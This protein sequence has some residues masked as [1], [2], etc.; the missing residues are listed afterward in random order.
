MQMSRDTLAIDSVLGFYSMILSQARFRLSMKRR[1]ESEERHGVQMNG[2]N[3]HSN[4]DHSHAPTPSGP[5]ARASRSK[6]VK[7][8]KNC[9][10]TP[11]HSG[12]RSP[13]SSAPT[14]TSSCRYDSSLG[15]LTKKFIELIKQADD[16]VLDLN[17]AADTLN[18][19]KRRIYDITNVLEGIGLIEKKLKNRI[20]WKRLGMARN[21][22]IKDDGAG[23]QTEVEDLL[24]QESNLDE[25]ISEIREQLKNLSEDDHNKQWLYV[26]EDDIKNL[27]CF[28]NETLIAIKAPLG[29]TLEVPDPDEAVEYPHRRFQILLRS[30]MGPIDVYLVSRF[31]G[32]FEEMNSAEIP[33]EVEHPVPQAAGP[34]SPTDAMDQETMTMLPVVGYSLTDLE[35]PVS[36]EPAS[37]SSELISSHPDLAGGI[38]RI[39]PAEAT[40]DTDYW[41]LSDAGVGISDIWRSDPSNAMWDEVV[42]LNAEFGNENMGSPRPHTPT[43]SNSMEVVPVS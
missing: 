5:R 23:T 16:G 34:P 6:T 10:L 31:E 19:Q 27:P 13:T 28:Q 32:K 26:T 36:H 35:P 9:P 42:R 30:N 20:R 2:W 21:A 14:P 38:M 11:G 7:Q 40:T 17:K 8:T 12:I 39:A 15:L 33:I 41:L 4:S 18:V 37:Q 24:N 43:S 1:N 22:D 3:G 29:T 25:S